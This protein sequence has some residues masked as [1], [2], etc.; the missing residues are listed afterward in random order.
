MKS[1]RLLAVLLVVVSAGSLSSGGA[2]G[3]NEPF[4]FQSQFSPADSAARQGFGA[5]I[6]LS[7]DGATALV[8]NQPGC[9]FGAVCGPEVFVF[10]RD[11]AGWVQQAELVSPDG[12][13]WKTTLGITLSRDGNTALLRVS[14]AD[15][16][17]GLDC[18]AVYAFA[19]QGTAWTYQQ[20]LVPADASALDHFGS[21]VALSRDG[22]LA[23]I[24]AIGAS[25]TPTLRC[26]AVY[27]F[28]R[29]GGVW[30]EGQRLSGD[31]D[32]GLYF[33]R[34]V[35]LSAD[36]RTAAIVEGVDA[37]NFVGVISIFTRSDETWSP[38]SRI[39]PPD[40]IIE[41]ANGPLAFSADGNVLFVR[42]ADSSAVAGGSVFVFV[43]EGPGWLRGGGPPGT[44]SADDFG[45]FAVLATDDGETAVIPASGCPT[46]S[47]ALPAGEPRRSSS[48]TAEPGPGPRIS[49]PQGSA[50]S[51][52]SARPSSPATA[53]VVMLSL[54][55]L[56][57]TAGCGTVYAF[58]TASL[59]AAIP[60]LDGTGLAILAFGVILSALVTLRRRRPLDTKN[61]SW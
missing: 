52:S 20:T 53:K 42:G 11:S 18:G 54:A 10:V 3:L 36:G 19:R 17:A 22:D 38:Q 26:G 60:A 41:F 61:M 32:L 16:A 23:L 33:G 56:S 58:T 31:P 39:S 44:S 14:D 34:D 51:S 48:G 40:G 21:S 9:A 27:A 43:R 13:L 57:C 29:S 55:G 45:R 7:S 2:W 50:A 30:T 59:A 28:T 6:Q 4:T 37:G 15:C 12:Q 8:A 25:C 24:G 5:Q 1:S 46:V 35:A 49:S 47:S